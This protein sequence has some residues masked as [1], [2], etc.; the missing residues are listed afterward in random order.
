MGKQCKTAYRGGGS[1]V[2]LIGQTKLFNKFRDLRAQNALP[3]FIILAG[4]KGQ[5]KST[6]VKALAE[7][8]GVPVVQPEALKVDNIR[9]LID[10]ANKLSHDII[11]YLKDAD[12]MTPQAENALLKVAEEPPKHCY[13]IMS[14][15]DP[16]NILSTIKSR[17]QTYW[18][19]PYTV[20][21][22]KQVTDDNLI[23]QC[24]QNIGQIKELQDIGAAK[25]YKFCET[26]YDNVGK[27]STLNSFNIGKHIQIKDDQDG[28]PLALFFYM[29]INVGR[30]RIIETKDDRYLKTMYILYD[31]KK[32]FTLKGVS[33]QSLFDM[34]ILDMRK[35]WREV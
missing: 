32:K 11:Y 27:V 5:G 15:T 35:I 1:D 30:K 21:Q 28:Y 20:E 3:Q 33:K 19:E 13:I 23:L 34:F 9:A 4:D 26:V 31:Y 22:L 10:E 25:L 6:M 12:D 7:I 16:A 2:M 18:L 8:M 24:A 29:M 14:I 17:G